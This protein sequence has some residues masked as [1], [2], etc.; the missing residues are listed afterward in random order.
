MPDNRFGTVSNKRDKMYDKDFQN[1][2][3]RKSIAQ[4]SSLESKVKNGWQSD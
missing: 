2:G 3:K 4:Y 1:T